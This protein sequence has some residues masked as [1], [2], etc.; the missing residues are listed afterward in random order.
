MESELTTT[1]LQ[2]Q[3][4]YPFPSVIE[5]LSQWPINKMYQ[6]KDEFMRQVH[7][8]T[9]QSIL[10]QKRNVSLTEKIAAVL[11]HERAR[12]IENPWKVDPPDEMDFW[13]D[14]R[15]RL[16][17]GSLDQETEAMKD[18][19]MALVDRIINRYVRE[20]TGNYKISTYRLA[21]KLLPMLFSTILNATTL[22]RSRL[23]E[24]LRI[25][26]AIDDLRSLVTKGTVVLV[27]THFSNLDSILIGWAADRIGMLAFS[28]GAGL[29]LYNSK[30]MS[31]FFSRLGAYTLDRRKKNDFYLETLKSFSQ[32]TIERGV[33]SLF[34]PGGTRSR[35]G[36]LENKLKL[37][38][39][40]TAI[41]AQNA[42]YQRGENN[43]VYIVPVVL[44]YHF[45]LEAKSLINQYLKYTGKEL[46]LVDKEGFGGFSKVFKFL[47]QFV[48]NS[49]EIIVNF[50]K[51]MDVMGNFVDPNGTS[52]DQFGREVDVRDYFISGSTVKYDRQRNGEYT[53]LLADKIVQRFHIENIV[54]SSHLVAFT[55]FNVIAKRF[56]NLDFYGILRLP[57]EDRTISKAL[58]FANIDRLRKELRHQSAEGKVQLSEIVCNATTEELVQHGIK[59]V[60][61]FHVKKPLKKTKTGDYESQDI[62]L[63]YYYHNRLKGYEL[64][65]FVDPNIV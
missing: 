7:E 49:S 9:V 52:H 18:N 42:V 38:L 32:L 27:P 4:S 21:R 22:R 13:S 46:Y 17:R 41:D 54:L 50:G 29:N 16:L 63:L 36:Q 20:I 23:R 10:S 58:L 64:S 8:F 6:D 25:V 57:K 45:V 60:G 59:N 24:K 28:Y 47:R 48:S 40:G 30:V 53:K 51:P 11:Y 62:N 37:G 2:Q 43:K 15:K 5:D 34:F 1:A 55:A 61:A 3:E 35:S 12:I 33:H 26:G 44:N 14:I 19:N 39:L 31:Y 56:P 65:S